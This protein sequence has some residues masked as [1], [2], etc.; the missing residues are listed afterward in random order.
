LEE[1]IA[2]KPELFVN[3]FAVFVHAKRPFQY[4]LIAGFK[5]VWDA[6]NEKQTLLDWG[7]AWGELVGFFERLVLDP[8]FWAEQVAED[9]DLTPNRDWIPPAVAEF[10]RAGT[11][12][13]EKAYAPALLPRTWLLI[14]TLLNRC[15]AVENAEEADAMTQAINSPKGKAVEALF[16]HALRACR[17]SDRATSGHAE[18]WVSL[19]PVFDEELAKCRNANYEFSTLAG[20][21]IANIEYLSK[22]WLRERI[23]SIF[24]DEF[25]INCACALNGLAYAPATRPVY[26]LLIESGV[27]DRA[28]RRELKGRH[29]RENIIQRIALAY[30]SGDEEFDLP[31]FS[32]LFDSGQIEDLKEVSRFF[33]SG[34]DQEVPE[35]QVARILDYWTRCVNWSRTAPQPPAELLSSLSRLICYVKTVGERE[36]DLLTAVAQFVDVDYNADEFIEGLERLADVSPAEVSAVLGQVLATYSPPF[37]FEDRLKALLKKLAAHGRRPDAIAYAEQLRHLPGMLGLFA[38]LTVRP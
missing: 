3:L 26:G 13:D 24:P 33:W 4:G 29:A 6:A 21:Y 8:G 25:A 7:R 22:D 5:R 35:N 23:A 11:R 15:D 18:V 14:E 32:Y 31:R 30:L 37:D 28:L 34:S 36:M 2:L 27:L 10:L 38:E 17:I 1:A 9:Q 20:A 19:R 12:D 16:S